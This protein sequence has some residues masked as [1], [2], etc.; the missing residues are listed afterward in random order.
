MLANIPQ[1]PTPSCSLITG[2]RMA[3]PSEQLEEEVGGPQ[4]GDAVGHPNLLPKYFFFC[5]LLRPCLPFRGARRKSWQ[6]WLH[7]LHWLYL[8]TEVVPLF[9]AWYLTRLPQFSSMGRAA[10]CGALVVHAL[11]QYTG[12]LCIFEMLDYFLL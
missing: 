10:L 9:L 1:L 2:Q 8:S 4:S 11:T 12:V 7:P 5:S 6:S 3:G